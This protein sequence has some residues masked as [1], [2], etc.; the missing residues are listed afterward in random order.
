MSVNLPHGIP[1]SRPLTSNVKET[2]ALE[3]V[4]DLLVLV[5]VLLEEALD[6]G[7]V[8]FSESF[9]RH[10]DDIPLEVT[11]GKHSHGFSGPFRSHTFL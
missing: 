1:S 6:F 2:T 11:V 10:V 5:Q 4:P 8:R 3:D 9:S 7:F